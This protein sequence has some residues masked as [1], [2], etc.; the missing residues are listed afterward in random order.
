MLFNYSCSLASQGHQVIYLCQKQKIELSPP[1]MPTGVSTESPLVGNIQM[2]S[3]SVAHEPD[4]YG[5]LYATPTV[6][7]ANDP[8]ELIEQ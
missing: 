2:R 7:L 8:S 6:I 5:I 1:V 3:A 4:P